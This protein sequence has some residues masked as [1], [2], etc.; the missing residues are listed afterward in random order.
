MDHDKLSG[1]HLRRV[2]E[3]ASHQS[4]LKLQPLMQD[5]RSV[6]D[7]PWPITHLQLD[8]EQNCLHVQLRGDEQQ[9][10]FLAR[11]HQFRLFLKHRNL[12][13][14]SDPLEVIRTEPGSEQINLL[15]AMPKVLSKVFHREFFRVYLENRVHIAARIKADDLTL[16][17]HLEDLS[18]G[19]CRI[20]LNP[21][22]ALK[23]LQPAKAPLQVTL[24][25]PS[26]EKVLR[27]IEM[28][29][30]QPQEAFQHALLGCHFVHADQDE[31]KRMFHYT[32]ETEREVAR[33][34]NV[35]RM[36]RYPSNLFQRPETSDR[37]GPRKTAQGA[38][39]SLYPAIDEG[40]ELRV[41]SMA[42]RLALQV[43]LLVMNGKLD[44]ARL[45]ELA[46]E[47]IDEL[48]NRPAKMLLALQACHGGINPI[49]LHSLRVACL[50]F[51][52]VPRIGISR[53]MELPVMVCLLLHDLGKLFISNQPC[54]N[55]LKQSTEALRLLKQNQIQLF[56]AASALKWIPPRIGESLM[57]NASER[58]DGS[59]YPRG[60]KADRLDA[61]ARLMSLVKVL[62]CLVQGYNDPPMSWREA[63]K[64][65]Y[66]HTEWFDLEQ[67][68][69]FIRYF[70]LRP[71]GCQ[72]VY[73][74][75]LLVQ[76]TAVDHHGEIEEVMLLKHLE[77]PGRE[78]AGERIRG[79]A[80]LERLGKI[81][82]E[83]AIIC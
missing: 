37:K 12:L 45:R 9:M 51:P 19:G 74:S 65:I 80:A 17:G 59:G 10:S 31:Q 62:D 18:A 54:F 50:M 1:T 23:L 82:G 39:K 71:V 11:W 67:L 14:E 47:L 30:L 5:D 16:R 53:G 73:S 64:W 27:Q 55:P 13:Y 66:R 63:F 15:L 6:A 33:L 2:L 60:L 7:E 57:V 78:V 46:L 26:G 8:R 69:V 28:S 25:F 3:A 38:R 56:R 52:L 35:G 81:R 21:Q 20:A 41:R 70:G 43:L 24:E 49:L 48:E 75:G 58:L 83:Q 44:A 40:Y 22:L 79:A 4:G 72:L 76:V 32:L 34:S 42:D 77:I 29:Y 36:S 68:K 61:L